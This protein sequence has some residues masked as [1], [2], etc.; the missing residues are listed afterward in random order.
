[1]TLSLNLSLG[2]GGGGGA[3]LHAHKKQLSHG[4]SVLFLLSVY[5]LCSWFGSFQNITRNI[6]RICHSIYFL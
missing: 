5:F 3:C 2:R 4:A 1:M 6:P